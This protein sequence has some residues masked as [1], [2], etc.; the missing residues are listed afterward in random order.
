[1]VVKN[2]GI[3]CLQ[4]LTIRCVEND[5]LS[6]RKCGPDFDMR[7]VATGQQHYEYVSLADRSDLCQGGV[8]ISARVDIF[9]FSPIECPFPTLSLEGFEERHSLGAAILP[10][11]EIEAIW[12]IASPELLVTERPPKVPACDGSKR[13]PRLAEALAAIGGSVDICDGPFE[14]DIARW[15]LIR[16]PK[17]HDA[18][19]CTCPGPDTF[20]TSKGL[21]P[22]LTLPHIGANL[23]GSLEN[24]NAALGS[25]LR[26]TECAQTRWI[27]HGDWRRHCEHR[28]CRLHPF[29]E[30]AGNAGRNLLSHNDSHQPPDRLFG[31]ARGPASSLRRNERP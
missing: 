26:E 17:N 31:W 28:V 13:A 20:N 12:R 5:R 14:P 19:Y 27:R 7:S 25:A 8:R 1:M 6:Q 10:G 4:G 29:G 3:G 11:R 24:G 23:L 30:T 21:F 15:K 18:K 22:W 16:L 9:L 2:A